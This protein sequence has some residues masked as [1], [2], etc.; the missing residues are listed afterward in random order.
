MFEIEEKILEPSK[1]HTGS[2]FLL[3]IRVKNTSKLLRVKDINF[4]FVKDYNIT[5]VNLLST[6]KS[7]EKLNIKKE[8]LN[9]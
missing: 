8:D 2:S 4:M 6:T 9:A 7:L 1:I 3:K 5:P